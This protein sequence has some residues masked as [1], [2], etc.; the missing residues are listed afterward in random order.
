MAYR[1]VITNEAEERIESRLQYILIE[2]R[3]ESA[4]IHYIESI[5]T[6]YNIIESNPYV[7]ALCRDNILGMMGYREAVFSDM[8][9]KLIY[10]IEDNTVYV[11]GVFNDLEDHYNKL[12]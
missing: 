8:N 2:L 7:Y 1:L 12:K 9:Y 10:R 5:E 4:A 6:I 11:M 3:N